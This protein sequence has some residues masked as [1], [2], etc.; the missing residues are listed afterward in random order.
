VCK[1]PSPSAQGGCAALPPNPGAALSRESV[2]RPSG[3]GLEEQV[4]SSLA[5]SAVSSARRDNVGL[6]AA[7]LARGP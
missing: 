4:R 6:R 2:R 7:A 5:C 3:A 1:V